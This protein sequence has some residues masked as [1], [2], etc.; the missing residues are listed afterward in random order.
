MSEQEANWVEAARQGDKQ[1]FGRLVEAYQGP[2]YNL[3]YRM[4]GNA[5]EAED[6]AQESFLAGLFSA[7]PV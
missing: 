3:T 7:C 5:G 4:L 2:I 1:A 6:A